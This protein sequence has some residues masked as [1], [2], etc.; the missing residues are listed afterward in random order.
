MA[1]KGSEDQIRPYLALPERKCQFAWKGLIL[2]MKF[3]IIGVIRYG[4]FS[5]ELLQ[6]GWHD[7]GIEK[8]G[9]AR[10]LGRK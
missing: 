9:F 2:G 4:G 7:G 3:G 1:E 8:R 6:L 5:R 10:F